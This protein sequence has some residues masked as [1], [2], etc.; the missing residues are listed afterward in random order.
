MIV[1]DKDYFLEGR[2]DNPDFVKYILVKKFLILK[3]K[4]KVVKFQK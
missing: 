3:G 4:S 2:K 1:Q